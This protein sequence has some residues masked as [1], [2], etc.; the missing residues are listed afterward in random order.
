MNGMN[1]DKAWVIEGCFLDGK[2]KKNWP[3]FV[4]SIKGCPSC[5]SHSSVAKWILVY[6]VNALYSIVKR[7]GGLR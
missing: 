4:V 6:P 1:L 7:V 5:S 3:T 2:N